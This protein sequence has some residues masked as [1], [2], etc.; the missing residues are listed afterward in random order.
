VLEGKRILV[1]GGAQG[2]GRAIA[3]EGIAQGAAHVTVA[4]VN[5]AGADETVDLVR[6]AGGQATAVTVD[7]RQTDQ[8]EAMVAAAVD[9][10][11]G[12]DV[13]VNNAGIIEASLVDAVPIDQLPEEV[14][15]AVLDIN[16]KATWLGIKYAAPHLRASGRGPSIVNAASVTGITGYPTHP[17]YCASKGGVV[18]LTKNAAVDLSPDIRVNCYCPGT[19]DTPMRQRFIDVAE[20]KD[21]VE[22]FM[23]A[24][25]LIPRPGKPEEVAKLVCFL[26][27]DDASFITGGVYLIDGGSLAWRGVNA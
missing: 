5:T 21:A 9:A 10:A 22:R 18:Q 11:G 14:W 6:A 27:S 23:S 3:L 12:L 4:D 8:I 19:V 24:S 7:L 1:T 26:A 25:H 16:L 2:M 20:D 13:L 15:D 17:A